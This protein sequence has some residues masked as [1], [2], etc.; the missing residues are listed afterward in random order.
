MVS[1]AEPVPD[2]VGD[3]LRAKHAGRRVV[4]PTGSAALCHLPSWLVCAL[5]GFWAASRWGKPKLFMMSDKHWEWSSELGY[6]ADWKALGGI[7]SRERRN[8]LAW[9]CLGRELSPSVFFPLLFLRP[10]PSSS[11]LIGKPS[12]STN[13][14]D[15][16][17]F[18]WQEAVRACSL[19]RLYCQRGQWCPFKRVH[20]FSDKITYKVMTTVETSRHSLMDKTTR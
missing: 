15:S 9:E 16:E 13:P 1:K 14:L 5:W 6:K 17:V 10:F 7:R 11:N 12:L 3:V 20:R 18:K 2:Q 8:S 19:F 4:L